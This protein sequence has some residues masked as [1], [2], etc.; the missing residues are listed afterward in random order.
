MLLF[1]NSLSFKK[2]LSQNFT[3]LF[4]KMAEN[5]KTIEISQEL[6]DAIQQLKQIFSQLTNQK[7]EKDEDVIWILVSWFI[8]SLTQAEN[9]SQ[10]L[11][12]WNWQSPIITE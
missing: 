12:W 11:S 3:F 5:T 2:A 10:N 1:K 8:E 4:I 7:I 6:Y 9:W